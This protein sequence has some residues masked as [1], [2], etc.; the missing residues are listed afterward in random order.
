MS[1]ILFEAYGAPSVA[2]G[3]DSLFSYKYNGGRNGLVVSSSFTSTHLIPVVNQKAMLSHATR[4]NWGRFQS[5]EYL[6]KLLKLKYPTFPGKISDPQAE[7]LVREHCYVSQNYQDELCHYLDWTGLEERSRI[8]QHPFVEQVVVEKTQ[9]EL[10]RAMERKKESGRRLQEQAAKM[11]LDKLIRKEQELV[12]YKELQVKL[13]DVS[14]K[15][16]KRILESDDFDD[17]SQLDKKIKEMEKSIKKARNKDLGDSAEEEQEAPPTFPLLDTP[18]EELDEEGIKQKRQQRLMKSNYDARQ[19]AKAEKEREKARIAEEERLDNERR[20]AD[21]ESWVEERRVAR[22]SLLQ[23]IKEKERLKSDLGNRKSLAN[24]M[25]M[26]SIANLASDNP[27]KKR[28]RG[29]DDDTFGADDADW[30][31]YRSIQTGDQSD[32]DEEE[33]LTGQLKT[34]EEQLLKHDPD[35]T[36]QSTLEAQQDWTKSLVHAFLYGPWPHDAE[37]QRELHQ[38]HLNVERIRVP[39]VVFQPSI[40]GLDQAGIVEIAS[41]I[42]TERLAESTYRDDILKDIFLTGGN[43]MF[44][45]FEDRLHKELMAVLP[46]GAPLRVRRAKDP[47]LDAW[48]GAAMWA[49]EASSRQHFVTRADFLEKGPDYIKVCISCCWNI[50]DGGLLMTSSRNMNMETAFFDR[51][52]NNNLMKKINYI[53]FHPP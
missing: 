43:T 19:R 25:R 37:S 22:Q 47:V 15:E 38:V 35:F 28:R 39:E 16:A 24:Q 21:P 27:T 41:S 26:K 2:Y 4:L 7:D 33:D 44:Q 6:L 52:Q 23:K 36:A 13:A 31:V 45:G 1:E 42:L 17:E 49:G 5:A 12:Y 9:E 51:V 30:S 11:R 8:I 32:D 53:Q 48:K 46:Q 20:E 50:V 3:I 10:D 14:K 34:L 18:D 40:A 29:G